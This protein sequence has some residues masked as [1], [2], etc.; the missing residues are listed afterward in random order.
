M[1]FLW[2]F[3]FLF[4]C[5]FVTAQYFRF[6][7]ALYRYSFKNDFLFYFIFFLN[8]FKDILF[9]LHLF[10]KKYACVRDILVYNT[11]ISSFFLAAF[12]FTLL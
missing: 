6:V 12:L 9:L 5:L 11:H 10:M 7:D 3:L 8:A 4:I 1:S 2:T